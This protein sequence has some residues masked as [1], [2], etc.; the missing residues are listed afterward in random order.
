MVGQNGAIQV[1]TVLENE[2]RVPGQ[3]A[4]THQAKAPERGEGIRA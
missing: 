1:P 3:L 2:E 4:G